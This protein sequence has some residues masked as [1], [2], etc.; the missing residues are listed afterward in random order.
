MYIYIRWWDVKGSPGVRVHHGMGCWK[1]DPLVFFCL[2]SQHIF[3]TGSSRG[4]TVCIFSRGTA[5]NSSGQAPGDRWALHC[6]KVPVP[7]WKE[8]Q[9]SCEEG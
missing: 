3:N 5:K 7:G 4:L 1:V 6:P 9:E 2:F 8:G